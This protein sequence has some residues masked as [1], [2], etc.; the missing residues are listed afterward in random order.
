MSDNTKVTLDALM[1]RKEQAKQANKKYETEELY[2]PSLDGYIT[3]REPSVDICSDATKMDDGY[4]SNRYLVYECVVEPN[5]HDKALQEA[6]G[7]VGD[8]IVDRVFK[9]GETTQIAQEC[10][11]LAGFDGNVK[12]IAREEIENTKN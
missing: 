7:I 6:Y 3:I 10:M 4:E 2:I 12:A 5:L 11:K 9:F 8:E 1:K